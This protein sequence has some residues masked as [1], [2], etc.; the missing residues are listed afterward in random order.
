MYSSYVVRKIFLVFL[1]LLISCNINPTYRVTGVIL[2][3]NP[4]NNSMLIDHD[5]IE[6]FMEPMIM[7][8]NIHNTVNVDLIQ[9]LDS[10]KF[11]LV[12]TKESHHAINFKILG[13]RIENAS[14]YDFLDEEEST[15]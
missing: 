14:E 13:K 5:K 9:P 3:K 11:D 12:I 8:F 10:V 6:G 7:N 15:N 1:L 2:E 4:E